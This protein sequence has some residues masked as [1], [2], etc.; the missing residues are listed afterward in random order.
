MHIGDL[1]KCLNKKSCIVG[2][3]KIAGHSNA[4]DAWSR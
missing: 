4:V 2:T 3:D 1:N